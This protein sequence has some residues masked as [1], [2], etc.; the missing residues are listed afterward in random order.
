[1]RRP[2]ATATVGLW[3]AALLAGCATITSGTTQPI[4]IDSEPQAANCTLTREGQVLGAITTPAP[5]TIK[6]HAATV[7]VVCK[8]PGYEDGRIVMNSRYET[9][10]SGN[11][12]LG[13]VIG[14]M[15]DASSGA[16]S[17]Y[18][19]S[20]LVRLAPLSAADRAAAAAAPRPQPAAAAPPPAP[21][22]DPSAP[23]AG[24]FDGDYDGGVELALASFGRYSSYIRRF[25]VL[26]SQGVGTGTARHPL[27]DNPGRVELTIDPAGAIKGTA[28]V[29]N[30][31][32]CISRTGRL[33]G[34]MEGDRM[35][36]TIRFE[37]EPEPVAFVL[38]R[39]R[40][41]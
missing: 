28:N 34:R 36:L 4:N 2:I 22:N 17:R 3:L 40:P 20:V 37:N 5:I 8:K 39:A 23:A 31:V 15:V 6:R 18:K 9:A 33:E 41:R 10:S 19:S 1:M 27:C 26:V 14:V 16:S 25:D 35:R 12:L 38:A 11:F 13:G 24:P 30:N 32:N 21:R 29:L 7:H